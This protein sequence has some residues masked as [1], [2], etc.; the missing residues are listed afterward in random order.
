VQQL[1]GPSGGCTNIQTNKSVNIY[2]YKETT[3]LDCGYMV[4]YS[5]IVD[6][7]IIYDS[8]E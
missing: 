2:I 6:A 4:K 8:S 3:I 1:L 5:S 7:S